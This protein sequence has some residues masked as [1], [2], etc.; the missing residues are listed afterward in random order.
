[1]IVDIPSNIPPGLKVQIE[2]LL[3]DLEVQY[4][5]WS[6]RVESVVKWRRKV[7]SKYNE[8][9]GHWEPTKLRIED[10]KHVM[11][12]VQAPEFVNLVLGQEGQD[13]EAHVLKMKTSFPGTTVIYLIEG[14]TV[15][16]RKNRNV[17]NRQFAS[18]VRGLAPGAAE[19]SSSAAPTGNRTTGKGRQ[20]KE[21]V[22]E[23]RIEDALLSLQVSH[24]ALIHHTGLA[25]E[26]AQWVAA[27]TQHISTIPYRRARDLISASGS[28]GATIPAFC[29]D[30]GQVRAGDGPADTYARMLQ[31]IARVTAPA[32]LG[33]AARFPTPAALVRGLRAGGP[34]ALQDCRRCANAD[35]AFSDRTVGPAVSRRVYKI[36]T[37]TDPG[38]TDV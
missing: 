24:G 13:L 27:F 4:E 32:A 30:A 38:S 18:A 3:R 20:P 12:I 35:G 15:W 17:L 33:I 31:E 16:M 6:G 25:V 14:L 7:A 23:D 21:Y 22:D 37:G 9:L 5:S 26:T 36:F 2:A 10:E 11:V 1:M 19:A 29:M 8:E 28:A 34:L